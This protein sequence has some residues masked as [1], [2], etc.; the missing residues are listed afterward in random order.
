ME[1]GIT[2]DVSNIIPEILFKDGPKC[3]IL[4]YIQEPQVFGSV[5]CYIDDEDDMIIL[6]RMCTKHDGEWRGY[7]IQGFNG[8]PGLKI[9]TDI[10]RP[11]VIGRGGLQPRTYLDNCEP[12][13][14]ANLEEAKML[15]AGK[16]FNWAHLVCYTTFGHIPEQG[17]G[18]HREFFVI[19][20]HNANALRTGMKTTGN[21]WSLIIGERS[22]VSIDCRKLD[23]EDYQSFTRT[24]SKPNI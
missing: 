6:G 10:L 3:D 8:K 13:L 9:N 21:V 17:R 14:S 18:G 23:I 24:P 20:L 1:Y 19:I 7:L 11:L 2:S 16:K 22:T 12:V 4:A 5:G 15:V